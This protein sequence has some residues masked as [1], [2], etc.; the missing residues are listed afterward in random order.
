MASGTALLLPAQ[1]FSTLPTHLRDDLLNAFAEIVSNYAEGR[2]EPAELNGGKLCEAAYAI[3]EGLVSG[4]MPARASKPQNMVQACQAL[5]K[6]PATAAPRSVRIQIP[7]MLVA[8]YEIRNNRNV[9]HVGVTSTPTTWTRC[10]SSRRP[11]GSSPNSSGCSI[12]CPSTTLPTSS[13]P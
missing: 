3:C 7:R 12:S 11:S 6:T 9:G 13:T 1:A 8:L 4:T 10:A 5:E 2:W